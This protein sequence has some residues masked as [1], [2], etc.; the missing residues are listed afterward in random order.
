MYWVI[1]AR[2]ELVNLSHASKIR[3]NSSDS[4]S[5]KHE[6][7]AWYPSFRPDPDDPERLYDVLFSSPSREACLQFVTD[8]YLR[9]QPPVPARAPEGA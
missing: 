8:L 1:T 3:V 2:G 9:L 5:G 4:L 6:V 7:R